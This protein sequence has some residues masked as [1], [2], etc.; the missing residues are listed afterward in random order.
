MTAFTSC[1]FKARGVISSALLTLALALLP[2]M[3]LAQGA[4]TGV[5]FNRDILPILQEKCQTC[6]RD[7]G[8]APMSLMT[9]EEVRPW[10]PVIQ[11]KV[12]NRE[13]PPWHI[14]R[15]I[16]IQEFTGDRSLSDSQIS[17]I[18]A[19]VEAGSPEGDVADMPPEVQFA[20]GSEWTIGKPDVVVEW[21]HFIR[22]TGSDQWGEIYSSDL[23]EQMTKPRWIKAIQVRAADDLSRRT[24]HHALTYMAKDTSNPDSDQVLA[25][26][27][28][29]KNAEI[30]PDNSGVLLDPDALVRLSY[31]T[32]SIGEE[33]NAK[34]QLGI[35]F[36]PEDYVPE[37][38]RWFKLMGYAHSLIDIP[39]GEVARTDGYVFFHSNA[40]I[41]SFQPHMHGLGSYQCFELIYPN[42]GMSAKTEMINCTN[43]DYNWHTVYNYAEEVAPIVPAGTVAHIISYYDNTESNPGNADARNWTGDGRRTIDEM[44]FSYLGWYEMTDAEYTAEL[45]RRAEF[46]SRVVSSND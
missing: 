30:Y 4:D 16:G 18:S 37:H 10:A 1:K 32:H 9:Y 14:D 3:T 20:D 35:V 43:W 39:P 24:V 36:Y 22:A 45:E 15:T 19:W 44:S 29:G 38:R 21:D 31:H 13:M 25:E 41:T 46:A 2:T 26:Y 7:Q 11:Y 8:I 27:S 12:V 5:T 17:K 33:V 40:T 42:S 34:V 6:H 28:S 23:L